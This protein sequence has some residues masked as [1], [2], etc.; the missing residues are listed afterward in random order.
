MASK[1]PTSFVR[2]LSRPS[3]R[4]TPAWISPASLRVSHASYSTDAPPSPLYARIKDDLK[5]AMRAK[6]TN[7]LSVLRT[8]MAATLNASKTDKPIKTDLQLV[9]LLQKTARKAQDTAA[10]FRAAGRADL[11]E[12]EEAQQRILEEYAA[13]SG[14]KQIGDSD[15]KQIITTIGQELMSPG[16]DVKALQT[17]MVKKIMS[18]SGGVISNGGPLDGVAIDKAALIRTIQDV[19]A[20]IAAAGKASQ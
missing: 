10:E 8:V 7:R 2:C 1:L 4:Q 17:Q 13:G 11:A 9:D 14:I 5:A 3:L 18:P 20:E 15:L 19:A 12:K 6:D 16:F